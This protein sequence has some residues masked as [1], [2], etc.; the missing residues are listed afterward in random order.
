V[1]ELIINLFLTLILLIALSIASHQQ[2][3]QILNYYLTII[4][5]KFTAAIWVIVKLLVNQTTQTIWL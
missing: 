5:T 1:I 2:S 4:D 3:D